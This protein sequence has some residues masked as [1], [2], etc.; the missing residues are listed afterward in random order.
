M[1]LQRLKQA[2]RPAVPEVFQ[3]NGLFLLLRQADQGRQLRH[4]HMT[5]I[6]MKQ[7]AGTHG[8]AMEIVRF[9]NVMIS[10][11]GDLA[12]QLLLGT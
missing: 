12:V 11:E 7:T 3:I 10:I 4:Q 2:E 1:L 8:S 5:A 9:L 6:P